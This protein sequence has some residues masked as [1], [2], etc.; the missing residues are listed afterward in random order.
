MPFELRWTD[1]TN[2]GTD[3]EKWQCFITEKEKARGDGNGKIDSAREL[4]QVFDINAQVA[5]VL[6]KNHKN[7]LPALL[8]DMNADKNDVVN[9]YEYKQWLRDHYK[10]DENGKSFFA[11]L[12]WGKN[13]TTAG[14]TEHDKWAS[15]I[16]E[17]DEKQGI[18]KD[19]KITSAVELRQVLGINDQVA[20][21]LWQKYKND[22]PALFVDM[23]DANGS[24]PFS[25]Y[26][27]LETTKS[28]ITRNEYDFWIEKKCRLDP[29]TGRALF[30]NT[31]WEE[32]QAG[33]DLDGDW[34]GYVRNMDKHQGIT[35]DGIITSAKEF[36]KIFGTNIKVSEVL[37]NRYQ[38]KEDIYKLFNGM[39]NGSGGHITQEQFESYVS[40]EFE[41][42]PNTGE[43]LNCTYGIPQNW[44]VYATSKHDQYS[45]R[46]VYFDRIFNDDYIKTG[47]FDEMHQQLEKN[48]YY[49]TGNQPQTN[50]VSSSTGQ[51]WDA[52][53]QP[54][55][56]LIFHNFY[57]IDNAQNVAVALKSRNPN[58]VIELVG[59]QNRDDVEGGLQKQ[60]S[61]VKEH[62]GKNV[63]IIFAGHGVANKAEWQSYIQK[64][65]DNN[66]D[67]QGAVT[68]GN[69]SADGK[70]VE[71]LTE[72][73]LEAHMK[74]LSGYINIGFA[75]I[76][77]CGA[78]AFT[79]EDLTK[80]K[81]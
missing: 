7:D 63:A 19:G 5:E 1:C 79:D 38:D 65:Y 76:D 29:D 81:K 27:D 16:K 66:G 43:S 28:V 75:I 67:L 35:K 34:Y 44:K 12:S 60:Y 68:T 40:N 36:S 15:Y 46:G 21:A 3:R 64:Q 52:S 78:G 54:D 14:V 37:F 74:V 55:H 49:T 20:K 23:N 69:L 32:G 50:A 10:I 42:N 77:I 30:A 18:T 39:A 13:H 47:N 9:D 8:M 59:V 2:K 58:V 51:P 41:I 80:K 6:W 25:V 70:P 22:I 31:A 73:R 17:M 62:P 11:D 56:V 48:S 57:D 4:S 33:D 72:E 45:Y 24:M 26:D 71:L 61:Y 53:T